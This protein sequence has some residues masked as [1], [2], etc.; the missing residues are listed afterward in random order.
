M[1]RALLVRL[2]SLLR[3]AAVE[4]ELDEE[5]QYHLEREAERLAAQGLASSAARETA[6]RTFGNV[7]VLKEASRDARGVRLV[8]HLV[9]DVGA[10]LRLARKQPG[11]AAVVIL[12][13][14]LGLGATTAVFNLT[15]NVLLAPL[16]LP[17]PERLTALVRMT[18][19]KQDDGFTWDEY[20]ALRAAP[21][22]GTL[23]AYRTAS[24]IV[25]ANGASHE[26]VNMHFVDGEYFPMLGLRPGAGRLITPDDDRQRLPVAVLSARLASTLFGDSTA[27][28]RTITIRGVPFTVVGVAPGAF[29][30]LEYP[31]QF[32]VAI[33][34]STLP[35]LAAAGP[36]EDDRGAPL[37]LPAG[38]PR[39]A[40]RIAGATRDRAT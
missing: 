26:Y 1:L 27:V 39:R 31:G 15:Y 34:L 9:R 23:A 16:A 17:H 3:P 12:S 24:Q 10:G 14:A 2:R 33:P 20:L 38:G 21:G 13:L 36:R 37:D 35:L 8:E 6:R 32:T 5:L 11:F 25:V 18:G 28:G 4:T 30:G 7:Q 22:V 19:D 40:Y 29:R